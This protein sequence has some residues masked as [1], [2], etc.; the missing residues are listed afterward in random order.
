MFKSIFLKQVTLYISILLLSFASLFLGISLANYSYFTNKSVVRLEGQAQQIINT[1]KATQ[2][3]NRET[4]L[5][6]NRDALVRELSAFNKYLGVS[7]IIVDNNFN[8]R[9]TFGIDNLTNKSIKILNQEKV[10]NGEKVIL[11]GKLN[12]IFS[13]TVITLAYPLILNDYRGDT[14]IGALLLSTPIAELHQSISDLAK[15]TLLVCAIGISIGFILIYL[16][17]KKMTIRIKD[18]NNAAKVIAEGD[19]EKRI[20]VTNNDEISELCE[21]FNNMAESLSN[22]ER[23][24]NEFISNISHDL[25]TPITTIRG[26]LQSILDG[27][28]K[29]EKRIRYIN[30]VMEET[31]RL[32][33]MTNDLLDLNRIQ[34][35]GIEVIKEE[36][37]I[38][39]LIR[40]II[41][42]FEER[43]KENQISVVMN[44]YEKKS[45][46][47][48]DRDKIERV[49]Y[50][51]IDNSIK[52]IK[53]AP[54]LKI[55]TKRKDKKIL[56]KIKDNGMGIK[57]S[58]KNKVFERFFKED[59]TRELYKGGSGLGLS[60]VRA[61][62]EAHGETI[63]LNTKEDEGCEFIFSMDLKNY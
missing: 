15:I 63:I 21:T 24:R 38:N 40:K 8:V 48:A 43:I 33:K 61:F 56:V 31:L 2:D 14:V 52:F 11:R 46:V 49:I 57:E 37:D 7:L 26:F 1:L 42:N 51:L 6:L 39:D 34:M 25:R 45:I 59:E 41:T 13:E 55:E 30:I 19:F 4:F 23:V 12:D 22:Q 50:N 44:L 60:I 17:S 20:E 32:S 27:T 3:F 16:F 5:I 28:A 53:E 47:I 10:I 58:E 36:F 62:I 29:E 18:I 9:A 54:V 35:L